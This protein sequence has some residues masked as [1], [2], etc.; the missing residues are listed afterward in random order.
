LLKSKNI[1]N[2]KGDIIMPQK[3]RG[4]GRRTAYGGEYTSAEQKRQLAN[5]KRNEQRRRQ[6]KA[7]QQ[8]AKAPNAPKA[9]TSAK[10]TARKVLKAGRFLGSRANIL[11][12]VIG[13]AGEIAMRQF[14]D[15]VIARKKESAG[16]RLRKEA[17]AIDA[18]F[19]KVRAA[20]PPKA[21]PQ[22]TPRA[23]ISMDMGEFPVT[24]KGVRYKDVRRGRATAMQEM[25]ARRAR[26]K[27]KK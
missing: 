6:T 14:V 27:K 4:G 17:E 16:E 8:A 10:S 7:Q 26:A 1:K 22:K 3:T 13:A 19:A 15:P 21:D 23:E 12:P 2:P 24:A 11:A 20:K 25:K 5:Q 18:E 9:V